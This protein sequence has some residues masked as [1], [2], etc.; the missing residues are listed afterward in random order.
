[1]INKLIFQ[2]GDFNYR[3]GYYV[4]PDGKITG[5]KTADKHGFYRPFWYPRASTDNNISIH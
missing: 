2:L 4:N 5:P 3:T 1:M